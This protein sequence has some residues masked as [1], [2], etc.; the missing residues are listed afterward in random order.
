MAGQFQEKVCV[1]ICVY[2]IKNRK[3]PNHTYANP[4]T[5]QQCLSLSLWSETEQMHKCHLLEAGSLSTLPAC[6]NLTGHR[7]TVGIHRKRQLAVHL[8]TIQNMNRG[9][10]VG[11]G[12]RGSW[13]GRGPGQINAHP[14]CSPVE[15]IT[16]FAHHKYHRVKNRQ[17]SSQKICT[18]EKKNSIFQFASCSFVLQFSQW[19]TN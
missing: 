11:A 10:G 3:I 13:E 12:V 1:L 18:N 19:V 2:Y 16:A 5:D 14:F 8:Q 6:H 15:I 4:Q 17:I 9:V 7:D